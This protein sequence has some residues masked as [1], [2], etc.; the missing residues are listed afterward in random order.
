MAPRE[1]ALVAKR[2]KHAPTSASARVEEPA[3]MRHGAPVTKLGTTRSEDEYARA[4]FT[5][6][7][8]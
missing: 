2:V 3:R 4:L 1:G 7:H 8:S 5:Y 6:E